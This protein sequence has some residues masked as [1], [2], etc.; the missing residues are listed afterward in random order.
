MANG[1]E[2]LE[3]KLIKAKRDLFKARGQ[4]V[5]LIG[6]IEE[7]ETLIHKAKVNEAN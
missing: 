4:V 3:C 2:L 5:L 7:L 6:K 1:T